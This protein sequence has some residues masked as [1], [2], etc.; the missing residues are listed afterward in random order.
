MLRSSSFKHYRINQGIIERLELDPCTVSDTVTGSSVDPPYTRHTIKIN[1]ISAYRM[2]RNQ[3]I[4]KELRG[5]CDEVVEAIATMDDRRLAQMLLMRFVEGENEPEWEDIGPAVDLHPDNCRK[6]VKR[7]LDS[8]D[9]VQ[10]EGF[11]KRTKR[12]AKGLR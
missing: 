10:T 9:V 3:R 2:Q 4:I 11:N 12:K 1:G 7:Y 5:R 6:A 8:L